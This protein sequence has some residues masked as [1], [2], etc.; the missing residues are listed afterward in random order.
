VVSHFAAHKTFVYADESGFSPGAERQ[1]GL[2]PRGKRVYGLR[3][4]HRRPRISLIAAKIE[5]SLIAPMLFDGTCNTQVFNA[6]LK[7]ELCPYLDQRHTVVM[8]N[9]TFHKSARTAQ[10]IKNTDAKLLFFPPYSP[11]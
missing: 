10:I 6:W 7:Q 3:S 4:G 9:A 8:D 5:K 2:A 1:Y 11:D